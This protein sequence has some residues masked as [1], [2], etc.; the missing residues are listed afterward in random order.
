MIEAIAV[1]VLQIKDI[2]NA[3]AAPSEVETQGGL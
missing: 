3:L 1:S 2:L